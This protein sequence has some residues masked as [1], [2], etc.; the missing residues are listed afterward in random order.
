MPVPPRRRF[1]RSALFAL[2]PGA[3][4]AAPAPGRSPVI[5][6]VEAL[7][8]R[9]PYRETFVLGRGTVAQAGG[10]GRYCFVRLETDAGQVGWGE[11]IALPSWSY[12]TPES[13]LSTVRQYL[14]PIVTGRSPFDHAGF[15]RQF[16]ATRAP[17]VSQGFPFAKG[18]LMTAVLDLAAQIAGVPLHRLFGGRLRDTVDLSF[19]LSIDAPEKMAQAASAWPTV[20][21][22]KV[23]VAGDPEL[24]AARVMAVSRARPDALLWVDANQSYRPVHLEA[25]LK[26]I[27]GVAQ[28]RCLEQPVASADWL[29]LKRARDK[30]RLP[31]AVDEGCFTAQDV[32]RL[33]RLEAADLV[34]L[35]IA[36]SGGPWNCYRSACVAESSGLGL[37]G[38]GLTESGVGLT[39]SVHLFSALDLVLPPELNGPKFLEDLLVEGLTVKGNRVTVPDAPGLGIRVKEDRLRALALPL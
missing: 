32:A 35:K 30:C 15:E 17:A 16:S 2:S 28:V 34:V 31:L 21:C 24:D 36:K 33:A 19:A 4:P 22:F 14:A 1:L 25:F 5:A 7:A 8:V 29:G 23:K 6:K 18:A 38:S 12:E 11:T 3:L 10:A 20:T 37:L 39:A 13:I 26:A 27:D 9:M